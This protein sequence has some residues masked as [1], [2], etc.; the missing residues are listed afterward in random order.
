MPCLPIVI[1]RQASPH[2]REV[3]EELARYLDRITG[4]KFAIQTGDGSQGVV[5]G[6]LAEFPC[7]ELAAALRVRG[8]CE[9]K[10]AYAVRSEAKRLL[11]VGATE[12][13]V[14]HAAFRLLEDLGCRWFF[15]AGEWEVVP[16]KPTLTAELNLTDRPALLARR[17]WWGY[18]FFDQDRCRKDYAAWARH[19]RMASSLEI[20]CGHAWQTIIA[21]H[22]K[23]FD[24]HPE[25]LA[26][27]GGKRQGPQLC[28]GNPAV[29]K[30]VAQDALEQF[31]RQPQRDMVSLETSDGGGHCECPAC[32][33][34]G[35]ISDRVFGLANEVARA[36]AEKY[37][38]KM[39]GLYA[40]NDHCEPPSFP[41]EPNVYVQSTAGFIRGKYTFEELM[42]LWPKRCRNMGFYDYLS[43]W[44]W[45]W[46]MPPGGRGANLA[47]LRRQIPRYVACHATSVDCESG[48]NWGVHGLGYYVANRLMWDSAADVDA[49]VADF[50]QQAFG[51]AAAAMRRYYERLDPAGEPLLSRDLL[52]RAL[53]DLAAAAKLAEATARRACPSRSAQAIPALRAAA[54]GIRPC[55]RQGPQA[56]PGTGHSH[57]RLPQPLEL[58]EPL[59]GD[60]PAV[61]AGGGQ[62]VRPAGLEFSRSRARE[63]LES[64]LALHARGN[65]AAIPGRPGLLSAAAARGEG[66]LHRTCS[67]AASNRTN[68]RR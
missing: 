61:D 27:V 63:T 29:R 53:R 44:M 54:V 40:Y 56:G 8:A 59:G 33:R 18:G 30:L 23:T 48:N 22:Q 35:N 32:R 51:P 36:V 4:G 6:T 43:V 26:L 47:Y 15:P 45:D 62:G 50:F 67:R 60:P 38:G 57:A 10:E 20:S 9:G 31:R 14:S 17:I 12:M 66:V 28:V 1:S 41:L 49:L 68:R 24:E 19:N 65:R 7:A 42:D 13:G 39:V 2:C 46:D 55:R 58:H 25:Y 5:L 52:A 3:A 16:T 64:G 21:A 11:L 37:P 34:L